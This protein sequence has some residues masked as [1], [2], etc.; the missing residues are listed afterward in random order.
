MSHLQNV[1]IRQQ[2]TADLDAFG[3]T[4]VSEPFNTFDVQFTYDLQPIFFEESATGAGAVSHVPN[5]SAAR[6]T[7][8]G[9]TSGDG[10]IFQTQQYARYQP[11]KSQFVAFTCILGPQTS[12]VRKRIGMFDVDNGMFFEQDGSGFSVV[13]RTKTSG[14]VVDD[15]IPQASWNQDKL[16]GTGPSGIIL[17]D[18]KDLIFVLDFQWLGAGRIRFGFDFGGQIIYFH[19]IVYA[20]QFTV[21][22]TSTGDLP[23]RVEIFNTGT[24]SGTT[25]LDFTCVGISSEGGFNPL[26]VRHSANTGSTGELLT[27]REPVLSVRPKLLFNSITNRGQI[28]P[29]EANVLST[30][31]PILVELF[32]KP[33]LTGASFS[34]GDSDSTVEFDVAATSFSGGHLVASFHVAASSQGAKLLPDAASKSLMSKQTLNLNIAGDAADIL[35]IA[36]TSLTGS[37]T[38]VYA[39]MD[40]LELR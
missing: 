23:F 28:L 13:R 31:E 22:F 3:R 14:S 36:A 5:S 16:D 26:G 21:P 32:Y 9:T 2:D 1:N 12:N 40:W 27:A 10:V 29:I 33:T 6:L 39:S 7:T 20:N 17:D 19:H 8:G 25:T 30:A 24:A 34:S 11:G 18:S 38:T 4:R 15:V 35:L 37:A